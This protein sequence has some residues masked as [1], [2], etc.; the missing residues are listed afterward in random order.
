MLTVALCDDDQEQL[1]KME[2][3]LADYGARRP[4]SVLRTAATE[5]NARL[6]GCV[7]FG[8]EPALYLPTVSVTVKSFSGMTAMEGANDVVVVSLP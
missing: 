2:G 1:A 8:L 4:E 3:L 7:K 6:F 5:V